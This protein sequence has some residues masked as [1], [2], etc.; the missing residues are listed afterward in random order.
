MRYSIHIEKWT[1]HKYTAWLIITEWTPLVAPP[2]PE[3]V[4]VPKACSLSPS[5]ASPSSSLPLTAASFL[6]TKETRY[7]LAPLSFN[8]EMHSFGQS[9][10]NL[11]CLSPFKSVT[12]KVFFLS[13][14]SFLP[15]WTLSSLS[16]VCLC[17]LHTILSCFRMCS[18]W[19]A[20]Q[21]H[22]CL[23]TCRI[24]YFKMLLWFTPI[25]EKSSR[26][27]TCFL[28]FVSLVRLM[29]IPFL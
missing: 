15:V 22:D 1:N 16:T 2:C 26:I 5:H 12:W 20:F 11:V 18:Y 25:Y 24:C 23:L 7:H 9:L 19:K 6:K 8:Y 4:L 29:L 14:L 3:M 17:S 10:P 13:I 21:T 28:P 27:W